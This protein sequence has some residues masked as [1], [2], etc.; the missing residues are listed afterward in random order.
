MVKVLH[1]ARK[2]QLRNC[3]A[4]FVN[5]MLATNAGMLLAPL[6]R[7]MQQGDFMRET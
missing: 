3:N 7:I 1:N 4:T 2:I 5:G 6:K